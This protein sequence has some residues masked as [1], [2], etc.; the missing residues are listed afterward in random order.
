EKEKGQGIQKLIKFL[1]ELKFETFPY[2][3]NFCCSKRIHCSCTSSC[4]YTKTSLSSFIARP[5]VSKFIII[6]FIS[7]VPIT[8]YTSSSIQI[9][10]NRQYRQ[11]NYYIITSTISC[12]IICQKLIA[13][14]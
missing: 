6:H 2:L 14:C 11:C 3:K 5:M 12:K 4:T 1:I 7:S 13:T 10:I 8:F 9:G